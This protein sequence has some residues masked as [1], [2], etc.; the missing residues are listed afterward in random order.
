MTTEEYSRIQK[1]LTNIMNDRLKQVGYYGK[2]G[3]GYEEAIL[4]VKS[5]LSSEFKPSGRQSSPYESVPC[6]SDGWRD[7][8]G[9]AFI[10]PIGQ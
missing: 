1:R 5:M 3:E 10:E 7:F 8:R 4:A 2:R 6:V 9:D